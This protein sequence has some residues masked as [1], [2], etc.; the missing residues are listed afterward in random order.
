M[1]G[2]C[3]KKLFSIILPDKTAV[4]ERDRRLAIQYHAT[5]Q[6]ALLDNYRGEGIQADDVRFEGVTVVVEWYFR[7]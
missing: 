7:V 6:A 4:T 2:Q 5:D 1:L 3:T